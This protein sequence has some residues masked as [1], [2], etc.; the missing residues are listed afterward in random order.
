MIN[1][2]VVS[3]QNIRDFFVDFWAT[4]F[5]FVVALL[6]YFL[7]IRDLVHL[8]ILF[9][10][11][12]MVL[13]YFAAKTKGALVKQK[14]RFSL[15]IVYTKTIPRMFVTILIL[16][17]AYL[18]DT[19]T[20]QKWVPTYT[21]LGWFFTGILFIKSMRNAYT[22]TNWVGFKLA[23]IIVTNKIKKDLDEFEN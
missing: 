18:W 20:K 5:G 9:F 3:F 17:M 12:E 7:P 21:F 6:G 15:T 19:V 2:I 4:I 23:E 1:F 14:V 22:V 16:M 10:I 11:I 13:G 8:V